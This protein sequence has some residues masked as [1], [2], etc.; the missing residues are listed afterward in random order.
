MERYGWNAVVRCPKGH[1]YD[2]P[3]DPLTGRI[4]LKDGCYTCRELEKNERER[5]ERKATRQS[6][7]LRSWLT[8][9]RWRK[10]LSGD[11]IEKVKEL[12]A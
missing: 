11:I 8:M 10:A 7:K 4:F 6:G 12:K 5:A 2:A 3:I 9:R 1:T